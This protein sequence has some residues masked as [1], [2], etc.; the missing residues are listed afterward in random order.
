MPLS[1]PTLTAGTLTANAVND[2]F[3]K[4]EDFLNGGID[5]TDFDTSS[6][7]V[8]EKH[9]VRPEFY[10]SPAPAAMSMSG[11][12]EITCTR[13]LPRMT[14]RGTL[15]RRMKVTLSRYLV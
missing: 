15:Q 2:M 10:G 12:L 11:M 7:W 8:T 13:S 9:V 1:I 6:K 4:L 14:S 5:K 3:T